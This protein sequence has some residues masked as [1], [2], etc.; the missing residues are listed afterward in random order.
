MHFIERA[1]KD[2]I[3]KYGTNDPYEICKAMGTQILFM[4][5]HP[6]LKGVYHSFEG[7]KYLYI[8][9]V[10]SEY[11]RFYTCLHELAHTILH[12]NY[13]YKFILNHTFFV[14][15]KYEK[16]V[17]YFVACYLIADVY[18]I[19]QYKDLTLNEIAYNLN[20]PKEYVELRLE[21]FKSKD[22]CL[23]FENKFFT[24]LYQPL[25]CY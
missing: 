17:E 2:M 6:S 18:R 10:F 5:M 25:L 14:L 3:D 8:N 15:D 1:V 20:V 4:D 19:L 22:C 23:G 21:Y 16:E 24:N 9:S 7:T 11:E 12:E 13:N